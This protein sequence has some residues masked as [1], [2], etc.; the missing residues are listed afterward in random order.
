MLT[1]R[2]YEINDEG[3]DFELVLW[4]GGVQVGGAVFPDDGFGSAFALADEI[5]RG[6]V[7]NVRGALQ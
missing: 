3:D 6:F 2:A 7:S 1:N 5:G 4:A